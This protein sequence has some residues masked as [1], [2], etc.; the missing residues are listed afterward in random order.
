MAKAD[1]SKIK[2]A[3][4]IKLGRKGCWE[5][6]CLKDG[7]LRLGYYG[8]PHKAGIKRDKDAICDLYLSKGK[9]KGAAS[10]QARQ[11]I[12]F[13]AA[14]PETLWITF[15]D[16]HLWWSQAKEDVEF[17]GSDRVKF[18][19]GSRLRRTL[20]GWSCKSLSGKNLSTNELSGKLTRSAAYKDNL[21]H[22]RRCF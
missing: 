8:V 1:L 3:Y 16:G 2:Q 17:L 15:T 14:G 5:K 10:D 18:P 19:D 22:Q 21:R 4:Y 6:M 11:V 12:D 13:Y 9:T 20:N 7:T